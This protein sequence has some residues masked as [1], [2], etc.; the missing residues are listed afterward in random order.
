MFY[1][2]GNTHP[3]GHITPTK[4]RDNKQ[5]ILKRWMFKQDNV[6]SSNLEGCAYINSML[7]AETD[8]VVSSFTCIVRF[9]PERLEIRL[10]L[11]QKINR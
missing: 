7:Y 11:V 4:I 10:D 1:P 3:V 5:P 6:L 8:M 2:V 9:M